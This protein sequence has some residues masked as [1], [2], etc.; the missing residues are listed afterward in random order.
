ME[1]THNRSSIE[2]ASGSR[3]TGFWSFL[4]SWDGKGRNWA[5]FWSIGAAL[6]IILNFILLIV[7]I[8]VG[9]KFFSWKKAITDNFV[10][11]L[12]YNFI[13]MDQATIRTGVEVEETIP[14]EFDLPLKK[15]TTVRLTEAT[16]ISGARVT[17][18]TGGLNIT[19]APADIILPEGTV[20]PVELDMV[21][22][23]DTTIPIKIYVPVSIPMNETELHD[24][25]MGLQDVVSPIYWWLYNLPNSWWEFITGK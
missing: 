7:L 1:F 16:R 9:W 13:L 25:F 10:G 17:M 23:V 5:R 14:V 18:S 4:P 12:Y 21:V 3:G 15:E 2:D 22:P 19:D 6:S 8:I 24:P 20:L 11:G